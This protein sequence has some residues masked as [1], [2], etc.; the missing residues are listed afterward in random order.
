MDT[1]A[2]MSLKSLTGLAVQ[3]PR[4]DKLGELTDVVIDAGGG[5]IV[6]VVLSVGGV[7]GM[8][9]KLFAVPWHVL[10]VDTGHEPHVLLDASIDRLKSAPGFD[11]DHWPDEADTGFVERTHTSY[12]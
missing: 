6:Y 7:L 8:G 10:R 11:K 3:N 9:E 4:G 12:S 1:T 2:R 5:R